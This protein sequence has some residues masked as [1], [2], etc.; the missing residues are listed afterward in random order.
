MQNISHGMIAVW[1]HLVDV[2]VVLVVGYFSAFYSDVL[3]IFVLIEPASTLRNKSLVDCV[4]I[5]YLT[6]TMT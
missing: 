3:I 5:E 2:N 6:S 1:R 4:A